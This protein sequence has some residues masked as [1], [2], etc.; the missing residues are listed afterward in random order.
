MDAASV[1]VVAVDESANVAS[2]DVESI[3]AVEV[4]PRAGSVEVEDES[5]TGADDDASCARAGL[6][7]TKATKPSTIPASTVIPVKNLAAFICPLL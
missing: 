7:T 6:T 1:T 5:F 3:K 4:S 2:A